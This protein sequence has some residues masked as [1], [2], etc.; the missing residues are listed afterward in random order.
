MKYL[1]AAFFLSVVCVSC[2]VSP[3]QDYQVQFYPT[4]QTQFDF[5]EENIFVNQPIA[6]RLESRI[7][8]EDRGIEG[9]FEKVRL[10][11]LIVYSDK[12][13][14]YDTDTFLPMSNLINASFLDVELIETERSGK[15]VPDFY[16]IWIDKNETKEFDKNIGYFT[17][18][19]EGVTENNYIFQDSTLFKI[20]Q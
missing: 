16:V 13:F 17:T 3:P 14:I 9:Q 6:L 11:E 20:E 1:L 10:D 15:S 4:V 8:Y 12:M 19:I 7:L 5:V 18:Y 2:E